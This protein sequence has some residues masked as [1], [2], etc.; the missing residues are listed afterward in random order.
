MGAYVCPAGF[1]PDYEMHQTEKVGGLYRAAGG[2]E[3]KDMGEK[4]PEFK[5][6]GIATAMTF[7]ATSHVRKP[8]AA[9]SKIM[10][11]GNRIVLDDENSLSYIE[12]KAAGTKNPLKI[13]NGV[14]VM[15]VAVS[16]T[17]MRFRG[18][19]N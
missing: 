5:T 14:Y 18:Q 17:K 10:A 13:E 12:N 6:N 4:R 19:A 15:E 3:L 9:A 16:P 1:F 11:K 2:Q 7:Q 8:L